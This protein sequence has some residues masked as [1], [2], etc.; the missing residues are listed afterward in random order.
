MSRTFVA[1]SLFLAASVGFAAPARAQYNGPN[2]QYNL[3]RQEGAGLLLPAPQP[4]PQPQPAP[5][6]QDNNPSQGYQTNQGYQGGYGGYPGGSPLPPCPTCRVDA[7][8]VSPRPE[9]LR[10]RG[11]RGSCLRPV[12]EAS[13]LICRRDVTAA[14]HLR[15]DEP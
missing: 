5:Q 6:P 14:H 7:P 2:N 9:P 10:C 11:Q 1:L 3:Q 15:A 13:Q 4:T 12:W 8:T